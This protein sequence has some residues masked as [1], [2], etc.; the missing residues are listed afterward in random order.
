MKKI[1]MEYVNDHMY[2]SD[3]L[4]MSR[5]DGKTPNGNEIGR[6]WVLRDSFGK[7][8]DFD[9]YRYDLAERNNIVLLN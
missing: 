3:D 7:W 4:V 6:R 9:T 8:I 2:K 5:E 1:Y